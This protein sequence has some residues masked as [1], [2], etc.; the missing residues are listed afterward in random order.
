MHRS[1]RNAAFVLLLA[2]VPLSAPLFAQH[3]GGHASA[4][5]GH[6][7]G[8]ASHGGFSSGHSFSGGGGSGFSTHSF[9]GGS[10]FSGSRSGAR[11][12]SFNGYGGVRRGTGVRIG[13]YGLRNCYG[14]GCRSYGYGYG[15]YPW[16]YAF[17]PYWWSDSGSSYDQD[18]QDQIGLAQEMNQQNLAE[19]QMR[20]QADQDAYAQS[21]PPVPRRQQ[22]AREEEE[23]T[24][25]TPATVLVFRDQ[26]K[27]EVQNYAIVGQ[28]LWVF[29]PERTQKIP[30]SE[31]DLPATTKA[32]DDRGVDFH[33][34]G[35]HEG[36]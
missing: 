13:T 36:Q 23:R 20:Q 30:L 1:L 25:A 15:Y 24:E 4:G 16:G 26:H 22:S 35:A 9:S 14:Y 27:Q 10:S 7:G 3:G 32:N 5:G 33:I 12:R 29:A 34:P 31:L 21:A 2:S 11:A 19:Q 17:D 28:M 6:G 8:F 18:Q